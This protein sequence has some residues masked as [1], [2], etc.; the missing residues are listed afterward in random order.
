MIVE[1][2]PVRKLIAAVLCNCQY[3]TLDFLQ[4]AR[5]NPYEAVR[6]KQTPMVGD[7]TWGVG[8]TGPRNACSPTGNEMIF[9]STSISKINGHG[10]REAVYVNCAIENRLLILTRSIQVLTK[11]ALYTAV[12]LQ[13]R[14]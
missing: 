1:M 11:L 8:L 9:S 12:D 3:T 14:K 4:R 10:M 13:L 5:W 7:S 2:V 6:S